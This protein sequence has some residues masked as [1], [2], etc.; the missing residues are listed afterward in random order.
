MLRPSSLVRHVRWG[1]PS[2]L[3]F[4]FVP[5]L[6][7]SLVGCA[8]G[9]RLRL[10][11][12]QA[13]FPFT[14]SVVSVDGRL[15][16]AE[17]GLARRLPVDLPD[18]R[19]IEVLLQRD[20]SHFY[21]AFDG[22]GRPAPLEVHPEILL[23]LWSDGGESFDGN[24][25]W[26]SVDRI[27]CWTRGGYGEGDCGRV[28]PGWQANL[29]PVAREQAVEVQ[30]SFDAIRFSETYEDRIGLC[31]RFLDANGGEVAIWPFRA[32]VRRPGTWAEVSLEH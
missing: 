3:L 6:L 13:E 19:T 23:D 5:A 9:P 17:W 2:R 30:I 25:W 32:E 29:L 31:F 1:S 10:E 28:L 11:P 27:L 15:E 12:D 24:D 18:G 7:G 4:L 8:D 16:D 14:D 26:F 20:R 21:F 22:L